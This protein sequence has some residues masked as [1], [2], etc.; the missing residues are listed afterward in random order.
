MKN[1]TLFLSVFLISFSAFAQVTFNWEKQSISPGNN[2]QE[3]NM[4]N[5]S[6]TL[7]VGYG[8][9]FV[10]SA[11]FGLTWDN[12]PILDPLYDF[13]DLSIN[14]N[15]IGYACS[16]DQKVI[17]NPSGY[18]P[19]VYAHGVLL[20]TID[21][22]VN[23]SV[24][25]ISVIGEGDDPALN[26]NAPGCYAMH[27]R[28]VEVID[29][30]TALLG[31]EWYE[32][33]VSTG[34]KVSHAGV[35]KTTDG[36]ASW[37]AIT[38][39]GRYP[40]AIEIADSSIYFGG[41]THLLKTVT[42]SDVVTDI[43]PNLIAAA[44]PADSTLFVNDITIVSE[45]EIYVTTS[46]DGIFLT[47][48]R[49]QTFTMLQSGAPTGGNDMYKVNDT[50]LIVLGSS[51]KSK[52]S[53]DSGA[54]WVSCYP[55]STVWEIGGVFNDSLYALAKS[56]VFK[57]AVTDLISGTYTWVEQVLTDNI[58][59]QKMHIFDA[60]RALI[61]GNDETFMTT[62]DGGVSWTDVDLPNLFVYGAEYDFSDVSTSEGASYASTRRYKQFDYPTSSQYADIYVH[63]LIYKS[64]DYWKTWE[65]LDVSNFGTGT[66]PSSNPNFL[67]CYSFS[68]TELE[69]INDTIVYVYVNWN[70]TTT[71]ADNKITHSRVF[72][73]INGGDTWDP[74]T[75][76]FGS[77]YINSIYFLDKDTGFIAG[78]TI[79]LKTDDGGDSFTD[80][81]PAVAEASPDDSTMF[82]QEIHYIN[83]N[84]WYLP[85]AV[86]GV[87][88]TYD[89]GA[90][91]TR[92]DQTK[93]AGGSGFYKVDTST[94]IV[95]GT[96][97]KS[98]I[99]WDKG[100]TWTN[101]SPGS[102][103]WGIG[104]VLNDSLV[105]M[106]KT[107]LYK[108]SLS[109]LAIPSTETDILTFVLD[110]QTGDAVIN[111]TD[112]TILKHIYNLR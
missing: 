42:G 104:G 109:N 65:L 102:S 78:N 74:I 106:G 67:G 92:F 32:H 90:T 35:F 105:A 4:V 1:F 43:Y 77:S 93:I 14:S 34:S 87:F 26:P 103:I 24:F 13:G 59:L 63:G 25:D 56:K 20:K 66:D 108:I 51:S 71:G 98:K 58:S 99:S 30:N 38:D 91:Y 22:G 10:K 110:E 28:S 21:N 5:D 3:M 85:T 49:G 47:I 15:G 76:D 53:V 97:S 7:L 75:K 31:I 39:N 36:G 12:V 44:I 54:T 18:E 29:D 100:V 61:I 62:D 86:D 40:M 79:L 9:T 83:E 73:T 52:A 45:S 50:V 64:M 96:T 111:T 57:I 41:N 80:L 72:K 11:D 112:H 94:Y 101:C 23:W 107:Y 55:G 27:F 6:T 69:C 95:L 48:D 37:I 81:Y 89:G 82:V 17:N 33:I 68:P 46:I 19:D 60:N 8:R 70:D 2:L 16:G 88:A 84:E